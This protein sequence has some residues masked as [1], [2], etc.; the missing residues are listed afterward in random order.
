MG[1]EQFDIRTLESSSDMSTIGTVFQQVWGTSTPIVTVE[2]LMAVSHAGGYVAGAFES[3]HAVGASFGFL[4]DH[5]GERAL[6]S[7]ITGI[8]PGV[9]HHGVGRLMKNHQRAWAAERGIPWI[10]WTFDPLVRRNAWFNI[11]VLGA[12]ITEYLENFYGTMTDSINA[13]D[14]SDRL[15]V[16]WPTSDD[17]NRPG[18]P[19]GA[20]TTTVPTPDDIVVLRR[21][22]PDTAAEW[23][24]Q[25]RNELEPLLDAGG[26]VTGFT[27]DGSYVVAHLDRET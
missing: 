6:H 18:A 22:E 25:V 10:V 21:T 23:R 1:D 26:I 7:H 24:L 16:A 3:G 27:R 12:H 8:L 20:I 2:L 4:A 19:D 5:H 17:A 11:E 14:E 9:Q 15:V 13:H